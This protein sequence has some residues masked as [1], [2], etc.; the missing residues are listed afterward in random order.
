MDKFELNNVDATFDGYQKLIDLYQY[1]KSKAFTQMELNIKKW[2]G[3]NLCSA[4]GGI[5][6]KLADE[7]YNVVSSID[8][9]LDIKQI[10]QKNG[11][12]SHFGYDDL[13]DKNHTTV[14]YLK[15]KPTDGKYF[16]NYVVDDLLNH[17]ELASITPELKR[18]IVESIYEMFV[19]ALIH[20]H[21]SDIYACGQFI[22]KRKK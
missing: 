17:S 21:S 1:Y 6:D 12:L 2:L 10:I 3:A 18:K 8:A 16:K 22:R 7:N 13:Y 20:S 15:L 11:F 9:S 5:L 14:K 4:L 19:N